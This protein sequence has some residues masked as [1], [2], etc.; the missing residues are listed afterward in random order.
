MYST[1]SFGLVNTAYVGAGATVLL[2]L[3]PNHSA[4]LQQQ[5]SCVV[6]TSLY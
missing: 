4:E 1:L 2:H 3:V 5:L 6:C